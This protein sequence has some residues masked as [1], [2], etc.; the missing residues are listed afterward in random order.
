MEAQRRT[1]RFVC[2]AALGD[3]AGEVV[4][5]QGSLEGWIADAPRG[6]MG[7]GYDPIF[8]PQG[9]SKTFAELDMQVKNSISHRRIALDKMVEYLNEKEFGSRNSEN[10]P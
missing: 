10:P 3:P 4:A 1:A 9:H 6:T 8:I 7:F 2:A 5:R